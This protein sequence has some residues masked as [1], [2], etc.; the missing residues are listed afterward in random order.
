MILGTGKKAKVAHD[1][2]GSWKDLSLDG[3]GGW[4]SMEE[5]TQGKGYK[6]QHISERGRIINRPVND[7][8]AMDNVRPNTHCRRDCGGG[9]I[10]FF[11]ST[12]KIQDEETNPILATAQRSE[13]SPW[14]NGESSGG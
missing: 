8:T 7:L 5:R 4:R 14:T 11:A 2:Y 6:T 13:L 10:C 9:D 1:G 3:W 12:A